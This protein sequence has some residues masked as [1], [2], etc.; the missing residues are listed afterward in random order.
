MGRGVRWG[1]TSWVLRSQ[2]GTEWKRNTFTIDG[3]RPVAVVR[4]D[5]AAGMDNP[6]IFPLLTDWKYGFSQSTKGIQKE[7]QGTSHEIITNFHIF[8]ISRL[9]SHIRPCLSDKHIREKNLR[10][11]PEIKQILQSS[12]LPETCKKVFFEE[13]YI[14]GTSDAVVW[15][16]FKDDQS[17]YMDFGKNGEVVFMYGKNSVDAM[18]HTAFLDSLWDRGIELEFN[19]YHRWNCFPPKDSC[20]RTEVDFSSPVSLKN[21]LQAISQ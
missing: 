20:G 21:A 2:M 14:P 3:W 12:C 11:G 19:G 18:S 16:E 17:L 5:A 15:V 1:S 4:P 13:K 9:H 6:Q 7:A 10:Y 8:N